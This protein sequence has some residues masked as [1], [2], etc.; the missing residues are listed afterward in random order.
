MSIIGSNILAGASGQG[1]GYTIEESLRFNASQ[2]SYLSWTPASAGNRQIMTFSFWMKRGLLTY[3]ANYLNLFTSYPGSSAIDLIS[4]SPSSD[5]LRVWFN[6]SSSADLITT[7]VFRDPS[8]WYHVVVAID[9]TQATPSNRI[10]VYVNGSQITS[11]STATYPSQNYNT[12]WNSSSYASAI[13]ANL[14]GPQGYFDGYLTEVNFIDG[15]ALDAS[16]FGETDATTGVWKPKKY[17]GTYGT[18]GFY[19]NFS[20][21][22]TTTTLG[23][24]YSGQSNNWLLNNFSLTGTD[25]CSMTDTPTPY[26]GGGNYAVLNPLDRQNSNITISD[27]NLTAINTASASHAGVRASFPES[28]TGKWYWEIATQGDANTRTSAGVG[29][30]TTTGLTGFTSGSAGWFIGGGGAVYYED[31]TGSSPFNVSWSSGDIL[32]FAYDSSTGKYWVGR[33]ADWF[34]ST[35]SATGDP[36]GGL[37]PTQTLLTSN[38]YYPYLSCFSQGVNSYLRANFGQRPFAYTPPTGFKALHTGNLPDSDIVDGSKHFDVLLHTGNGTTNSVSGSSFQP[39]LVWTKNRG[40]AS[41][42]NLSNVLSGTGYGLSSSTTGDEYATNFDSFDSGGFTISGT[43]AQINASGNTYVDWLWKAN[44]TGVSNGAGSIESTVSAN[45]AAGFSVVTYTGNGSAGAT[46]G[47]GLGVAPKVII[48]KERVGSASWDSWQVYHASLTNPQTSFLRLNETAGAYTGFTAAWNSTNPT[49]SVFSI[50]YNA[51]AGVNGSGDTFVAYCF[52]EVESYSKFGSYLGNN[53]SD[54]VFVYLGF[55]PR[56]LMIKSTSAS[57]EWVMIDT[58]RSSY[59]LSDTSLYAN[60][61]YSEATITAVNDVD[62]LSNGFKLRNNTGYVN[63][64]QTYIYMA[65]A[66]TDFAHALA[67]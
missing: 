20:D 8:A 1:G 54:G 48:V 62:I 35:G 53:S 19:L 12:Y 64:S 33:N 55:R 39:D 24:D 40:T 34:N 3:S 7:Q 42:H 16:S 58:E 31:G 9:T 47:H 2:S 37:N 30:S 29:I 65:F 63:A 36:T 57:T 13:G 25:Y 15:Q 38:E 21:A 23:Y 4:F 26:L 18:N 67:R 27:G 51:G 32:K 14:N 44:G 28:G 49:N 10:K 59:N 5:S 6:G 11:F 61:N 60:R 46:V 66:E 56:F 43:G 52:A 45:Q 22:S 41:N 17:T 50:S